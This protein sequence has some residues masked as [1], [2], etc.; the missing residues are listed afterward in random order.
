[1]ISVAWR[2]SIRSSLVVRGGYG[3]Y[4]STNI[5]APIASLLSQQPP[6]STTFNVPTDP[7]QPLTIADGLT[8]NGRT[9]SFNN[10]GVDPH[11]HVAAAHNWQVSVQRD[12]QSS[13]TLIATYLGVRGTHLMQQFLPNTY[14]AGGTNPCPSCPSGFRYL[15]SNG[16]SLRNA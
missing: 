7:S 2:P 15:T 14:P 6:F 10:F 4:R 8:N 3:I 16:R 5:Y 11:L 12:L 1:R 9:P 13:L